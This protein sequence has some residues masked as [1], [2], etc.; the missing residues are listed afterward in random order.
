[1][2]TDESDERHMP[3]KKSIGIAPLV[4]GIGLTS[5][6][7]GQLLDSGVSLWASAGFVGGV[8]AILVGA[9]ILLQWGDFATESG[10]PIDRPAATLAGIALA[11][12]VL[13][14]AVTVV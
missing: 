13:G 9:G 5:Q 2:I 10:K 11:S 12:F 8:A 3:S 4:T 1:M 7:L 6:S 14:A